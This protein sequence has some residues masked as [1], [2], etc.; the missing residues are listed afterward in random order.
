MKRLITLVLALV[1]LISSFTASAGAAEPMLKPHLPDAVWDYGHSDIDLS[2][3]IP[4]LD[5]TVV[6]PWELARWTGIFSFPDGA[7]TKIGNY[8]VFNVKRQAADPNFDKENGF[9]LVFK[10]QAALGD[11]FDAIMANQSVGAK[12]RAYYRNTFIQSADDPDF[13]SGHQF[14]YEVGGFWF[15][16]TSGIVQRMGIKF[17]ETKK[18][19]EDERQALYEVT[20]WPTLKATAAN[21]KLKLDYKGYGVAERNIRIVATAKGAFPD[22]KNVISLTGGKLINTSAE[23]QS[24]T[25]EVDYAELAEAYGD[26]IDVVMDD[27]YGR[28]VVQTVSLPKMLKAM[29]YIPTKLTLTE[30]NQLWLKW[31]YVGEDFKA[32]DYIDGRGIPDIATV[33][34]SGPESNQQTFQEMFSSLPDT[35]KNGQEYNHYLGKVEVGRTPGKYKIS[36]NAFVNNPSHQAR[37]AEIPVEA[38]RNNEISAEFEVEL[39]EID[40]VALSITASP[41]RIKK[42]DSSSITAKVVNR[43]EEDQKEVLI[44]ISAGKD[45]IYEVKKDMPA[46]KEISVGPVKWT[47]REIGLHNM[48]VHVDPDGVVPDVNEGNNMAST[49]CMVTGGDVTSDTT[50]CSNSKPTAMAFSN[51]QI[52]YPYIVRILPISRPVWE[53]EDVT[54]RENLTVTT[55]VNTRQGIPTDKANPKESD[56][57]S[58]GSWEIIPWAKKNGLNPNEVTRAGYGYE[59]KVTTNYNTNW[60]KLVPKGLK[61][62]AKKIGGTYSGPKPGE[63]IAKFYDRKGNYFKTVTL[64]RTS[65]GNTGTATWELPEREHTFITG[66]TIRNRKVFT[67]M[68]WSDGDVAVRVFVRAEDSY[69]DLFACTINKVRIFGSM[70]EDSQNVRQRN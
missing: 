27:G 45:T 3:Y 33:K 9:G 70:F 64:E 65:G 5:A 68:D 39:Q 28:T 25:L 12:Q 62:T 63:V 54:Y 32:G 10:S 13:R 19:S 67:D 22:L 24:G 34:V 57:D 37:A 31:K 44:R 16:R 49:G 18:I 2:G 53:Y 50:S 8:D 7:T 17:S 60:E 36:V 29:D 58:R 51:W 52:T 41:S 23:A 48:T 14:Y 11:L 66:E 56:V 55:E 26:E 43:S 40:L 59:L 69:G 38:Y 46:N 15:L 1:I 47:G 6:R 61:G 21:G 42:G 35:I 4:A 20:P 30:G